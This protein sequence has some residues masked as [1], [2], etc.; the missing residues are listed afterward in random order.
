MNPMN[1]FNPEIPCRV[2][3]QLN[4]QII[5]WQAQWAPLYRDHAVLYDEGV[6]VWDGLLLDGWRPVVGLG[7]TG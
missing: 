4:D 5:E 1:T 2:H 7:D 3:D 6:I